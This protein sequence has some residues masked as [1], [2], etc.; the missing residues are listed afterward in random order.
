MPIEIEGAGVAVLHSL[1]TLRR[2][3]AEEMEPCRFTQPF[4][5]SLLVLFVVLNVS[6]PADHDETDGD[7]ASQN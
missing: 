4:I 6:F 7:V 5:R 1:Q 3:K 2:R